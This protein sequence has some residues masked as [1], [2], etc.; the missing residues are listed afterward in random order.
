MATI[1]QTLVNQNGINQIAQFL[2]ENHKL[3]KRISQDAAMLRAWAADAEFGLREGND[4]CIEVRSWDS[5]LGRTQTF[6]VSGEG[7]DSTEVEIDE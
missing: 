7:L 4:A 3:G 1:T 5:V 6:T 2:L